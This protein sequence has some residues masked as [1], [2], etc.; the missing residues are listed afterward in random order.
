MTMSRIKAVLKKTGWF[1]PVLRLKRRLAPVPKVFAPCT[2]H[3]LIAAAKALR[4]LRDEGLAEG[5]DYA[6][7]GIYRGF[8]FWYSQ[9]TARDLGVRDMRFFGFDSFAGLPDP[10]GADAED[11]R[12]G[13]FECPKTDVEL[14]LNQH[15]VDWD[16]TVLVDGWYD[17]TLTPETRRKYAMRECSLCVIDCD[18][19]ES[20]RLALDFVGPHIRRKTVV[21]FD[22]WNS[23]GAS[24]EKGERRAFAEFLGRN[25]HLSAEPFTEFG[26]HGAGFLVSVRP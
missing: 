15:G 19:Y 18:L 12:K 1:E 24:P 2:P 13:A 25:P 16:R 10:Q 4:Y 23:F 14:S 8:T 7:F 26:G 21:L 17:R 11:F 3:L 5:T 6:E 20:T 22:D 9:A